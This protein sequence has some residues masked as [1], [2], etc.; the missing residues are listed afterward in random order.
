MMKKIL[1]LI[2]ISILFV[3]SKSFSQ[4]NAISGSPVSSEGLESLGVSWV[5]YD[6]DGDDDLFVTISAHESQPRKNLLF[7]NNGD[8]TFTKITTGDLVNFEA[9]GRNSTWADFNND[10]LPDVFIAAQLE[11]FL[12][13]NQ[14]GGAF[15][16][17]LSSPSTS[18]SLDSDHS[19]GAWGD[20]NGDGFVDLF[21]SSYKLTDNARNVLYLNNK[22]E[23]F[24]ALPES[25]LVSSNGA[26]MDPIWIDFDNNGTLDLFVPNYCATNFLYA[27]QA[28]STFKSLTNSVLTFSNCSVGSS[29]ADY[30]NDGDFDVLIQNNVNQNN[31]FFENN[32]DGSFTEKFNTITT[33]S[34]SAASWGDFNND[35]FIDLVIA[36]S[37]PERK[38][39][40]YKNNGDKSFTDVSAENGI[41]NTNYS[42]GVAWADYDK[43]GFLDFFIANAYL[44]PL[45]PN[46]I[47]YHNTP[48]ANG[49]I[50]IK[51]KGTNSN[52]SAIGA[53]VKIKAGG[54][55]Q[56]RTVQSKTGH[57]SQNS[58]NVHFGIGQ[59]DKIDSLV[60]AWPNQGTQVLLDQIKNKFIDITE[61][62]FPNIP[63]IQSVSNPQLAEVKL[64]WNDNSVNES[65]FRIERSIGG[66]NNFK[67]VASVLANVTSFVDKNLQE[68]ATYYYRLASMNSGGFS[69]Y[70]NIV[71][72]VIKKKQTITF[73][74][75][76]VKY[77]DSPPFEL[78]AT[79][80]SGLPVTFTII[81][82]QTKVELKD[83]ELKI[84]SLGTSKI[85]SYQIGNEVY[86]PSD[87][88]VQTLDVNLIT[89]VEEDSNEI[90]V[91]PNPVGEELAI[92]GKLIN[93]EMI[94]IVDMRGQLVYSYVPT[95]LNKETIS[96][97]E[98]ASGLYI[99]MIGNRRFKII[100]K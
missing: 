96:F 83:N 90:M 95:G 10:G 37:Y 2:T 33:H 46:D 40:L 91:Y 55:W 67:M 61:I 80:S 59:A 1:S 87:T 85:G 50:N 27:N 100:K 21:L 13:K 75:I 89:G 18:T 92:S 14:G 36:G 72:V 29:W 94:K 16:K 19:G 66:A 20:Y 76:G 86:Y 43:D 11:T 32:G 28:D 8:G 98:F 17:Q 69:K 68:G 78:I 24:T 48:N 81:D 56:V 79:S 70:S 99:L 22:D 7:T 84:I 97:K 71:S 65:G 53:T 64:D 93:N 42:W 60:V 15:V 88:V 30:D 25:N 54:K 3:T 9:T 82:G 39:Y 31:Q 49:W 41:T 44:D 74:P 26:G 45:S 12:F 47:L 62:D 38:T 34:S 51:L 58:L 77:L 35:G 23:S 6:N 73:Q 57:N 4:F 5:D 63:T 52:R